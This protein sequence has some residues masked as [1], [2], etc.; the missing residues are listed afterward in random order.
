ML[1]NLDR[2]GYKPGHMHKVKS[3]SKDKAKE[4]GFTTLGWKDFIAIHDQFCKDIAQ[5]QWDMGPPT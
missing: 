3:V 1:D 4:A 5:G 2:I